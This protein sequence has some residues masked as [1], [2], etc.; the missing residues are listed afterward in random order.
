MDSQKI[1]FTEGSEFFAVEEPCEV[2]N[3]TDL[4]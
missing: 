1:F 3:V 2:A 4:T